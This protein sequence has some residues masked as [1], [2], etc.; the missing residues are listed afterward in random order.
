MMQ[1]RFAVPAGCVLAALTFGGCEGD[2]TALPD[3][4]MATLPALPTWQTPASVTYPFAFTAADALAT[5]LYRVRFTEGTTILPRS[6]NVYL[7]D[8]AGATVTGTMPVLPV[9]VIGLTPGA[10]S[11]F[12][13]AV[14]MPGAFDFDDFSLSDLD[15]D[16]RSLART[17]TAA[18]QVL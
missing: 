12:V 9:G 3:A 16:H 7:P 18:L 11:A 13:E 14:G 6:W 15:R 4:G 8:G 17:A 5:G 1:I 10:W 2:T